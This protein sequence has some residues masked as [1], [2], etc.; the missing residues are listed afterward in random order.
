MFT[1]PTSVRSE[2]IAD[3][4]SVTI[5]WSNPATAS[6]QLSGYTVTL[7]WT[8]PVVFQNQPS[9]LSNT[10]IQH[11]ENVDQNTHTFRGIQPYSHNC[12]T[13]EAVYSYDNE[14]LATSTAPTL[15]FNSS[16]SGAY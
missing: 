3:D 12:L 15:C 9:T 8:Q 6:P 7:A 2:G 13:V 11:I 1:P 10:E 5:S 4:Y 16:S 14:V